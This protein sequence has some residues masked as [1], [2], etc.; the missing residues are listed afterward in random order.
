VRRARVAEVLLA[1]EQD[2]WIYPVCDRS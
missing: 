2:S 1:W